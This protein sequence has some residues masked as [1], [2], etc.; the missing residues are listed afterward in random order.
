[1]AIREGT[2]R[3]TRPKL[4]SHS[5]PGV[6]CALGA[7]SAAAAPAADSTET[8]VEFNSAFLQGGSK[9]DV[10]RFARGNPVLPGDYM[11]DL[12][13][14][15][16]WVGR[17]SVRFIAQP[18]SDT[19]LPCIDRALI[20]RIGLDFEKLSAA[21]NAQ[22]HK[23]Q[24]SG[25]VDLKAMIAEA[26]V[27]FDLSQL[28]LDISVPQ[29]AMLR[30]PRGYV[31]PELWDSGV[32]SA[33][34]GYNLNAYRAATSYLTST[35]G[36]LDLMAGVNFGSW[37]LRQRSSVE[38]TSDGPTTFQNIAT[39][40]THDIPAI[41]SDLTVGDSFTDGAVFDSFG[42]RGV[43]LA[44]DDQMLPDSQL[45][46][47]P[48]VRGVA[49]TNARVVITQNGNIILET[50]VSPGSFEIND[51]YATGYGGDLHVTVFE[52]D[53]TQNTFIVPYASLVQLLRPGVWRYAATAGQVQQ[54]SLTGTERFTQATVQ[55]GFNNWLTGYG[56]AVGAQHYA[57]GLLG[58]AVNT[59]FGAVAADI[60]EARAAITD[61]YSSSGQSLRL[62]Y[63]KLLRDTQTNITIATY[64]YSSSGFYAFSDAQSSRQAVLGGAGLDAVQR[65]RSQW[66]INVSQTLPRRWGNFYLTAS[67]RDYWNAAGTA[68][69]FQGGYTNHFRA[70][71]T[72]LS[73]SVAI[74]RQNNVQ[75]GKP[76]NRVSMNF[77]LP[78]GRSVHSPMF[79]TNFN[80][81]TTGGVRTHT[82]QE[83]INGAL[84]QNSQFS[85]SVSA[86]QSSGTDSYSASSQY[87][88]NYASVSASVSEGSG[89]SQ[90]SLGATGGLVVHPGGVTLSNQMGDTIGIIEAPGAEGARVTN[91]IGTVINHAGFAVLPFL[92]PYRLNS[93][94][95]DPDD[96]LSPDVEFKSTSESVAPRL[97]S[98]VMIR[99]QTVG[100]RAILITAHL[101]DGS[102]I[103][104]GASVYDAKG[105]EV[106]LAGQDGGIYLRG[107]PDSGALTARWG[108]ASDQQCAFAYRLPPQGKTDGP[109]VRID[110]ICRSALSTQDTH[111]GERPAPDNLIGQ[112]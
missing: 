3:P 55:H 54:P 77:S 23:V 15:G 110:T 9:V 35:V 18:A 97:N 4:L 111:G 32:P 43:S 107:I 2:T 30:K 66:Q 104:F 98:V 74:T 108:E 82:G 88:G 26:Q 79:S 37:H 25:C 59:A 19:A 51:L 53:G 93:I 52:A 22:L 45:E 78:L 28:Q 12:L 64:R 60:T 10:S 40:L 102:V 7:L 81:D 75:T 90:Q 87:R 33:T 44:S 96:A 38:S 99:F 61:S 13:I 46:Y 29:A 42:F 71:G 73:Y 49:Q 11:V 31:G 86:S 17:A 84:G 39:Y 50:T 65:A 1:V 70:L 24:S 8:P 72:S 101:A 68:T 105:S 95:I 106:G 58:I 21:A 83:S 85:Y 109:F 112:R 5:A 100:G 103:P 67:V 62:S 16:T 80:E 56:G 89:Y 63:S 36:H 27:S 91:N 41:R 34:L 57:A 6:L 76:D 69:Q 94:S 20:A 48:V 92:M 47:A 14:N